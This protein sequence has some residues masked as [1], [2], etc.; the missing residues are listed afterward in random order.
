[1]S[2]MLM[3]INE[4]ACLVRPL[5]LVEVRLIEANVAAGNAVRICRCGTFILKCEYGQIQDAHVQ[6][7]HDV[8]K[9]RRA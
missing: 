7:L 2:H 9:A 3:T 6:H 1:M 5:H 8:V 4:Y